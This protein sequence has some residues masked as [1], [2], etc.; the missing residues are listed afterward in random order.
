MGSRR[1]PASGRVIRFRRRLGEHVSRDVSDEIRFHI[2]ERTEELRATGLPEPEARARALSEFGDR[3]LA[4]KEL[5][6]QSGRTERRARLREHAD[7]LRRDLR[8]ALRGLSK[9]PALTATI[10]ST[11]GLGLGATT[12]IFAVVYAVLIQ[13]LPFADSDRVVLALGWDVQNGQ[14]SS[15]TTTSSRP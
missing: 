6:R 10:V 1:F 7:N 3:E 9:T 15:V 4:E 13:P 8:H 11:V 2:E 12:A 14:R 5:R